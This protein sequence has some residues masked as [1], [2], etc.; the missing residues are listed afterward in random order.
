V[1]GFKN[2]IVGWFVIFLIMTLFYGCDEGFFQS[3]GNEIDFISIGIRNIGNKE[4]VD[5]YLKFG[6]RLESKVAGGFLPIRKKAVVVDFNPKNI[7]EKV[8]VYYEFKGEKPVFRTI[9]TDGLVS[10]EIIK[11][12]NKHITILFEVS[13]STDK[14]K[15]GIYKF[16]EIDGK[17]KLVQVKSYLR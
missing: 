4:L 12:L 1:K 2:I 17:T 5:S 7:K 6:E 9:S 3:K 11:Q 10:K 13:N 16:E 8:K 15:I 14:I